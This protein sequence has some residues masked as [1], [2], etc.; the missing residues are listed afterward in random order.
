MSRYF[1]YFFLFTFVFTSCSVTKDT[2]YVSGKQPFTVQTDSLN[3]FDSTRNR[4]IPVAL[5]FPKITPKKQ[6][7]QLVLLSHGYNNNRPGGYRQY[8]Y[9]AE[10][11]AS[12][13]YFVA[14]IQHELTTDSLLPLTGIPQIVRRSNW[15]RGVINIL[16]VL[17]TFRKTMPDLNY[18]HVVLIGHSNGGDMSMLFAQEHSSLVYKVISLDNRRVSLPRTKHPQIYSIRSSDQIADDGVLP[19]PQEQKKY[20]ITTIKLN[21]TIHNDMDDD[22][23]TLQREE[24]NSY[25]MEFLK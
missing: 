25:I 1:I 10:N 11:L 16:F 8:S 13:G 4:S 14:S 20:G 3:L 7:R 5:Y 15:E 23:T 9:I 22:A 19:S 12:K 21:N 24:I 18:S 17:N 6:Y 2:N